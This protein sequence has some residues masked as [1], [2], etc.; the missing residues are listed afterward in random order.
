MLE[1]EKKMSD[2]SELSSGNLERFGYEQS[3][4]RSLSLSSLVFYGL[5]Y[6]A[7]MSIF[8]VYGFVAGMTHGMVALSYVIATLAMAFTAYSYGRMAAAYPISGSVYS[9]TQRALSPYIGFL[10]G[11]GILMDYLLLPMLNCLLISVFLKPYFPDVPG[12][13]WIL[14]YVGAATIINYFGVN[15]M[16]WVNNTVILA[17][18]VF[19]VAF[20]IFI[21]KW[22]ITGNGAATFLDFSAIFNSLEYKQIG[23]LNTIISGGSI[24]ALCFLGFDAITTVSEEAINPEKNIGRAIMITCLGAGSLFIVLSYLMQL[25]WPQGWNEFKVVDSG[26]Q[27]L[28]VM[29]AGSAMSYLFIAIYAIG[30]LACTVAAQSSAS[31]ILFGM[32]R[33][34]A[35]PKKFFAYVHP[36]YKV[37]TLNIFLLAAICLS[38]I[39]MSL[40][41]AI[42]L[43]N[44]GA[45]AGFVMVNLCVISHY[46]IKQHKRSG[47]DFL[48]YL[49][50]PI[51]GAIICFVLW[52]GLDSHSKILGFSWLAVGIIY[53]TFLTGFFKKLPPDMKM[54]E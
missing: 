11:W 17:Q 14:V 33:D 53:L 32:G 52:I 12:W 41:V 48:R 49:I 28:I 27:E 22:L 10:G 47:F 35:L 38:A 50:A 6:L 45:L 29:V 34:G 25:A 20:S 31:R 13:V 54:Q 7:P 24:L 37:P 2:K 51:I 36:K 26:A 39:F 40:G 16:A 44:F 15:V 9:Y 46:F 4:N 42:S 19:V 30:G 8:S 23:G 1:K 3:F 18:L 43:I 21:L 5:A